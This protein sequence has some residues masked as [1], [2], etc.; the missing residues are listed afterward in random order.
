MTQK[1]D[2]EDKK[3]KGVVEHIQAIAKELK[4]TVRE[5]HYNPKEQMEKAKKHIQLEADTNS[6][7]N[8]LKATSLNSFDEVY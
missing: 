1:K 5:F 3:Q 2:K 8:K 4:V 6:A 7:I